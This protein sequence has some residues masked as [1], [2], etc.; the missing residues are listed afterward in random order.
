[1]NGDDALI[2]AAKKRAAIF[3][4]VA[5]N[6]LNEKAVPDDADVKTAV[7]DEVKR[8]VASTETHKPA[9][10]GPPDDGFVAIDYSRFKPRGCYTRTPALQRYFRAVAWLQAIPF[11]LEKDEELA[12]FVL[13]RCAY[14]DR[15]QKAGPDTSIWR[16]FR[17][18]LGDRDDW[19]L[20]NVWWLPAELTKAAM[21]KVHNERKGTNERSQINDQIRFASPEPGGRPELAFRFRSAYRLPDAVM[22]QRAMSPGGVKRDFPSGLDVA[23]ALGSPFARDKYKKDRPKLLTDIDATRPL[24]KGD[25]LY[26]D[27]LRCL[28][29]L[30]ERT[31]P[32]APEFMR[33]EPWRIKT[34]QT[35]LAGWAQMRHTW[36][37]QAKVSIDY[38][39]ETH[40]EAG[41]VEPVPEF[42]GSLAKLIDDTTTELETAGA[43]ADDEQKLYLE[44]ADDMRKAEGIVNRATAQK[45]GTDSFTPEERD[46]LTSLAPDLGSLWDAPDKERKTVQ[47][48]QSLA[49]RLT[50]YR[51]FIGREG[52]PEDYKFLAWELGYTPGLTARNWASLSTICH[53]LEVLA[54]KQLRQVP[55]SDGENAF[56]LNYGKS[57]ARIMF[58]GGNSYFTPKDDAMR[59]VDVFSNP[60]AGGHLHVGIAR[61]RTMWVVYPTR[62]GDVLCRGAIVPYAEFVNAGRLTD[63]E[64][65]TL[66]DSPK[67]PDIPAWAKPVI[68]PE[69]SREKA[70]K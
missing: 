20:A 18:F 54:H 2:K 35:A 65:K 49:E 11:R 69:R 12:A 4:G 68:P 26:A 53:R 56:I 24:F 21:E 36:A 14:F 1:M 25:N 42:Y 52:K 23:A 3:L 34:T 47:P 45:A 37:L 30:M 59:V 55:F 48:L 64:W 16:S 51:K 57:L 66:L 19:D 50:E 40:L 41:L 8:I 61:P 39:S 6:L 32:D 43:L 29:A 13:M 58:Y 31:E 33:S 27:Y 63:G 67:R 28:G 46:L 7:Q 22:F 62:N 9:W 44:L 15:E 10:L 38:V 5:R 17:A 60:N 70:N